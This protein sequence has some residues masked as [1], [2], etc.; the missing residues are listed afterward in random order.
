[1]AKELSQAQCILLAVHYASSADIKA[2]HSFTPTRLDALDPELVLRILLT[3]LPESTEPREYTGYV[4]EVASR[5]YLDYNREEVDVDTSPVAALTEEQA[6]KKVKKLHLPE[7]AAPNFPPDAPQDLL[8]R[9]LCH[10][11]YR[12][13]A[14]TGLLNLIPHLVEP[15]VGRNDFLRV[16]Y[17]SVVLPI[18]RLQLEY[19][20][21]DGTVPEMLLSDFEK[22]DGRKGLDFLLIKGEQEDGKVPTD[23]PTDG[24]RTTISRDVKGLV[25]PFMFA[26]GGSRRRGSYGHTERKR[27][28]L[29]QAPKDPGV[30][31][32]AGDVDDLELGFKKVA[33]DGITEEDRTGHDWEYMFQWIVFHAQNNFPCVTHC[34]EDWDG[35][36]DVDLG[37]FDQGA[38]PYLDEDVQRKLELQYA[39]AAFAACYA[40]Q[41]D[42][43]EVVHGAHGILARLAELL[44]FI[45]PPDLASSIELLPKIERHAARIEDS[46]TVADLAPDMLLKAEHPLTT[47]RLE[48]YMLLQMM[49]YSA[50]QFCGLGHPLSLI[51]VTRLHFYASSDEQLAILRKILSGLSK[52]GS[53]KDENRWNA[54]RGKLL[55][56]WNWGIDAEDESA[57][58]GAGVLGKIEKEDFEEEMLKAF[59]ETSCKS[60]SFVSCHHIWLAL[61]GSHLMHALPFALRQLKHISLTPPYCRSGRRRPCAELGHIGCSQ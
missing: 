26:R 37:G 33:L 59:V 28:K 47:P 30:K 36:G 38:K 48:T 60:P 44:D 50:Y 31:Q 57:K 16:W 2:L 32:G 46:Q 42:T 18:L 7:L 5:L 22:L 21:K 9:F 34:I 15:F 27:R 49:V 29:G 41:A 17:I 24:K 52:S 61:A 40:A 53:R 23:A 35:P 11:A 19:Y 13:D 4:E 10:R 58:N 25:G 20:P 39:Q 55:W 14:E 45:P 51:K 56:L 3:Y 6:Q 54:E 43:D 1:M 8:T 12:I